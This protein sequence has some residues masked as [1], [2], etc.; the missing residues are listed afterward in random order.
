MFMFKVLFSCLCACMSSFSHR[1]LQPH[2]PDSHNQVLDI[3]IYIYVHLYIY[4]YIYLYIYIYIYT[5]TI[6]YIY[7]YMYTY[8]IGTLWQDLQSCLE[9]MLISFEQETYLC[10][11]L[12]FRVQGLG[13]R[14]QGLPTCVTIILPACRTL[15]VLYHEL[16]IL[17]S[18]ISYH[19]VTIIFKYNILY[20]ILAHTNFHQ[21][22]AKLQ[23]WST[24]IIQK[25]STTQSS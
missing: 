9:S 17:Q 16:C 20:S 25:G 7:I 11:S 24:L 23:H 6:Q 2:V 1:C 5:C 19:K 4:I 18:T 13:F 12:L 15:I 14:V 21:K 10:V 8:Q 3:Y 22:F